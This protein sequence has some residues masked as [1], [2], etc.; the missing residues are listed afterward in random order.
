MRK[1]FT[2]TQQA[3]LDVLADN[4]LHRRQELLDCLDDPIK[5]RNSLKPVLYRLRKKL[6]PL[7]RRIDCVF[8]DRG[9]WYRQSPIL[10]ADSFD[11]L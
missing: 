3:I 4:K 11:K 9:F 10:A 5:H 8:C 6:K 7:G 1:E 2:P